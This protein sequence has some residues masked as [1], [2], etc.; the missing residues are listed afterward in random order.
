MPSK[1]H[2]ARLLLM[3]FLFA[4]IGATCTWFVNPS[5]R[6]MLAGGEPAGKTVLTDSSLRLISGSMMVTND[7]VGVGGPME[8]A[9]DNRQ[10][11]FLISYEYRETLGA[12][13]GNGNFWFSTHGGFPPKTE[14]DDNIFT[15]LPKK[16]ECYGHVIITNIFEFRSRQDFLQFTDGAISDKRTK[17]KKGCCD[18]FFSSPIKWDTL[19]MDPETPLLPQHRYFDGINPPVEYWPISD[20]IGAK[21]LDSAWDHWRSEMKE[22]IDT[23]RQMG[24]WPWDLIDTSPSTFLEYGR[25]VRDTAWEKRGLIDSLTLNPTVLSWAAIDSLVGVQLPPDRIKDTVRIKRK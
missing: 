4:I 2:P 25:V 7:T 23:T 1:I 3:C 12:G 19:P 13:R 18:I 16:R 20:T 24:T 6:K 14:M 5:F 21:Y 10:R 17:K 8:D 22:K 15:F 11:Y 9:Y